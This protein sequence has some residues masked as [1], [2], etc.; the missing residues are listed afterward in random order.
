MSYDYTSH[1]DADGSYGPVW[2]VGQKLRFLNKNGYDRQREEA[3]EL[4]K[5]GEIV[6]VKKSQMFRSTSRVFLE[7]YPDKEFNTVMFE[8]THE[9]AK[10]LDW[11]DWKDK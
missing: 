6:T 2:P 8:Q 9:F 5:E 3:A 7:E 4:M 1:I 11:L 10:K